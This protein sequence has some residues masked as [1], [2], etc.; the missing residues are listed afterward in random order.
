[1]SNLEFELPEGVTFNN[2]EVIEESY[3]D[4]DIL[5]KVACPNCKFIIKATIIENFGRFS[6]K[7]VVGDH[8][9][10][11]HGKLASD[12]VKGKKQLLDTFNKKVRDHLDKCKGGNNV[13]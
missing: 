8:N 4:G 3:E 2:A 10:V 12:P 6:G 9:E 13:T 11:W 7:L 5:R 1:M